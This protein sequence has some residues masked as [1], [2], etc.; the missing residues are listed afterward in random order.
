MTS[1]RTR[2][3]TAGVVWAVFSILIGVFGMASYLDGLTQNRFD[4]LL[5]NRHTQVVVEVANNADDP[6]RISFGIADPAYRRPFSGQYWQAEGP[7]GQIY[8]SPSL[9]DTLLPRPNS[10]QGR[11]AINN[12]S[13]PGAVPHRRIHEWVTLADGS[14]WHIQVASSLESLF[15]DRRNLRSNLML[16]F[17]LIAAIGIIAAVVQSYAML[18]P[19]NLL[20][21]EVL[22]RWDSEDGLNFQAYPIEVMPLV[23]DINVLLERNRDVVSAS[24]RQAADLAHAVKTPSSIVRNELQGLKETG[25]HV[26]QAIEAL[27][28]LDAQL[29]RSFARMRA[30][31]SSA[32]IKSFTKLDP[33]LDRMYRAFSALARNHGK[34]LKTMI[35]P[36][37]RIRMD[38][39]DFEEALGNILDNALKWSESQ[40]LLVA[41]EAGDLVEIH[42][43]DDGPGILEVEYGEATQSGKRLDTSK[44][45][46]GLGLAIASDLVQAYGGK[47]ILQPCQ[48]LGGLQVQFRLKKSGI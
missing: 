29:K 40:I 18:R 3:I 6:D 9:V 44:P 45:G 31:G 30:D 17:G 24:R 13:G 33:C 10:P 26:D 1:M 15:E 39:N 35:A 21:R 25:H 37:L 42:V 16:A 36:G 34:E 11:I 4:E 47:L 12:F 32:A 27:D 22:A 2:A 7:D 5:V 41:E 19:L 23:N 8:V 48:L 20:R 14:R 28:R 46:T 43:C 38:Q